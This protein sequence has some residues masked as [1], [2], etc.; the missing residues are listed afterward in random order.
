MPRPTVH[1]Y[2]ARTAGSPLEPFSY[3]APDLGASEVRVAVTHCGVC[4]T[5]VHAID[6]H[7]GVFSFPLM[8]GHEVVGRLTELG[9]DVSGLREGDLVGVGWQGRS[10]GRCEWCRE[11]DD[12]LCRDIASCGTWTP[13]GGFATEVVVD[14]RFASPIPPGMPHEEAAVLMCAGAAVYPPLRR[15]ADASR[16]VGI[17]GIG[18]LGHLAIQFAHALGCDVTAV[19]TSPAKEG[20][21]R[22]F[23]ADH[24]LVSTDQA[25]MDEVAFGFDLLLC[26]AH[27]DLDWSNLLLSLTKR[28]R[29]VLV[30]FP[31]LHLAAG[32]TAGTAGPLVDLVVH[33]LTITGSFLGSPAEVREMLA[34]AQ[35]HGITPLVETMPMPMVNRAIERLRENRARYRIVLTNP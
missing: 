17:V 30:A 19:S 23:G 10:C 9:P 35:E 27:G 2:A 33:E 1:G 8:P 18:G 29:L 24:F 16:R 25:A 28:G 4:F 22:A 21:A 3:E 6:D 7:F 14:G 12:H 5:D 31:P 34:F 26:T 11:G 32:G 13:Y 20:E 15:Y